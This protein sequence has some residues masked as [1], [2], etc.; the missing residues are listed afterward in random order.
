MTD[1][2]EEDLESAP[3]GRGSGGC[4]II[5]CLAIILVLVALGAGAAAVAGFLEPV[6]HRFRSPA[7]VVRLYLDAYQEDDVARARSFLCG[8]LRG[9]LGDAELPN[10]AAVVDPDA[11]RSWTAG[12]EDEFPYPRDGG[13]V[14]IYYE[15][16]LPIETQRA[17]ALL[18]SED[19]WRICGFED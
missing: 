16:R 10:P 7:E 2:S 17:Q 19:G 15:V 1:A 8:E 12:V 14:G 4:G 6:V 18:Q 9:E 11:G 3:A 13:R 5:G